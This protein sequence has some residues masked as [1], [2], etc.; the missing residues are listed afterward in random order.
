MSQQR[1]QPTYE[2]ANLILRLYELR[3]EEQLRRARK[4]YL[5]E[6]QPTA[7]SWSE[8]APRW[9]T[10]DDHDIYIRMVLGYW[11]MACA[12]V[13]QGVLSQDL[14]FATT[15]EHRQVWR[16]T[17]PWIEDARRGRQNPSL[18]RHLEEVVTASLAARQQPRSA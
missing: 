6:F 4:W 18:C 1:S 9:G 8:I 5:F 7:A 16:K 2:D 14:F 13:T 10:G 17:A 15:S 3:R 12:F 11:D